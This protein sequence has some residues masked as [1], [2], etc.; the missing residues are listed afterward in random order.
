MIL[1]HPADGHKKTNVAGM[2]NWI[3]GDLDAPGW[4]MERISN[5]FADYEYIAHTTTNSTPQHQRW[6]IITVLDRAI[7]TEEYGGVWDFVNALCNNELDIRT[8]N[9]NRIY[10]VAAQWIGADNHFDRSWPGQAFPVD[11]ILRDYP[12]V[13]LAK[14]PVAT[15]ALAGVH[16]APPDDPIITGRMIDKALGQ[17]VGRRLYNIM[18]EAA[19]CHKRDGI[20]LDSSTL[21]A[22]ALLASAIISP[23]KKRPNL[24]AEATHAL[25]WANAN[26]SYQTPW[27]QLQKRLRYSL[28]HS[29]KKLA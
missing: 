7:T 19:A 10:Y 25:S 11:A 24:L 2:S 9:F 4:T 29:R 17:P 16:A 8:R 21:A 5:M 13:P 12:P 22:A 14:P 28:S 1:K 3:A 20:P 15:T 23:G 6:R 26:I 18:C 27:Q